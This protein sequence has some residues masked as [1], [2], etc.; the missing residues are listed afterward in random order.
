MP[1]E[2]ISWQLALLIFS[3]VIIFVTG[4]ARRLGIPSVP[5]GLWF[6]Y[7]LIFQVW[8]AGQGGAVPMFFFTGPVFGVAFVISLLTAFVVPG[9]TAK[10]PVP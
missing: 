7:T 10:P 4:L 2:G 3:G 1:S 5:L 6:A 9:K 8:A